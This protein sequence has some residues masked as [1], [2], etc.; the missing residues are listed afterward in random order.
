MLP[1][2]MQDALPLAVPVVVELGQGDDWFT[3]HA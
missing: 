1:G 3:A 2:L